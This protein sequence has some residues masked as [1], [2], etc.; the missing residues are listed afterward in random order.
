[1]GKAKPE[2]CTHPASKL[3]TLP[4]FG[5]TQCTRCDAD[6]TP[7]DR[8]FE[9]RAGERTTFSQGDR[10]HVKGT[11]IMPAYKGTFQWAD[12]RRG[13]AVIYCVCEKQMYQPEGSKLWHEGTAAVR[14]PLAELVRHDDGV[15]T[16]RK[17]EEVT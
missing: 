16:R 5:H 17:R 9:W 10:V 6:L 15:R 3:A 14:W 4:S 11:A 8:R 7:G 2:T 1:M 13:A 12:V